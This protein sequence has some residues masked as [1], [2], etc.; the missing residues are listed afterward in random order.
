M[1]YIHPFKYICAFIVLFQINACIT[2]QAFQKAAYINHDVVYAGQKITDLSIV[3][4]CNPADKVTYETM[5]NRLQ[6]SLLTDNVKSKKYYFADTDNA[7]IIKSGINDGEKNYQLIVSPIKT[8]NLKDELNNPVLLKQIH[9]LLQKSTGEKVA[10]LAIAID[11]NDDQNKLG[12][13]IAL[14]VIDYLRKKKIV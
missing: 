6:S 2:S 4:I 7:N 3:S 5:A 12:N 11:R 13:Q 10:E 9:L 14:L 1:K 8:E